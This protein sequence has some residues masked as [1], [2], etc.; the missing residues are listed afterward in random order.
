MRIVEHTKRNDDDELSSN[1]PRQDC[2][3]RN[4]FFSLSSW[5]VNSLLRVYSQWMSIWE[6]WCSRVCPVILCSIDNWLKDISECISPLY[7]CENLCVTS[8]NRM[9]PCKLND[10]CQHPVAEVWLS[11]NPSDLTPALTPGVNYRIE[12]TLEL[13]ESEANFD[14]GMFMASVELQ[15]PQ[16]QTLKS[17]QRSGVLI[18]RSAFLRFD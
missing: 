3:N 15:T 17:A 13:P 8:L 2:F 7:W 1:F 14:L 9:R 11:E 6:A 4:P 18:Y 10:H 12:L 16:G 5:I